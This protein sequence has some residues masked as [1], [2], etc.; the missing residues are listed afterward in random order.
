MKIVVK[1]LGDAD[2]GAGA[3][4][5]IPNIDVRWGTAGPLWGRRLDVGRKLGFP[6]LE[7]AEGWNAF[8]MVVAKTGHVV[9]PHERID[10]ANVNLQPNDVVWIRRR[11][12]AGDAVLGA[13]S[14][15]AAQASPRAQLP[16]TCSPLSVLADN[17]SL[18]PLRI[19]G[20]VHSGFD[21]RFGTPQQPYAP[22]AQPLEATIELD[23]SLIPERAVRDLE[24]FDMIW[25]IFWFDRSR[26]WAPEVRPPRGPRDV[27]RSVLATRSPD[28]PNPIGL[29]AIRLRGVVGTTLHVEGVDM[30]HG[31][32]VLDIKPYIPYADSFPHAR[33]GWV[34][35]IPRDALQHAKRP[36]PTSDAAGAGDEAETSATAVG[37]TVTGGAQVSDA[38]GAEASDAGAGDAAAASDA[39]TG[40]ATAPSDAVQVS[41]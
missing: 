30:L 16:S 12:D 37:V 6:L 20:Y 2:E 21:R 22:G 26:G 7:T 5:H 24:G 8:E 14:A 9:G 11:T 34:D 1:L 23:A 4:M 28:R 25:C 39:G 13:S 35:T 19:I 17:G 31:T 41:L 18:P 36:P 15:V 29:S 33:A 32:P 10:D 38:A 3:G 27:H 40:D